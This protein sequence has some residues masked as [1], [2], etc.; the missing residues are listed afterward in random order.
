VLLAYADLSSAAL[1]PRVYENPR[2][3]TSILIAAQARA[4]HPEKRYQRRLERKQQRRAKKADS[5]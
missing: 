2:N 1:V 5:K 3:V 4:P